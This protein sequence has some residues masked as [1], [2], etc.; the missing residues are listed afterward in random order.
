V[1]HLLT[2]TALPLGMSCSVCCSSTCCMHPCQSNWQG[3][4]QPCTNACAAA[5]VRGVK[6][7]P[8]YPQEY[9]VRLRG[10]FQQTATC[11]GRLAMNDPNLQVSRSTGEQVCRHR[12][13]RPQPKH[14]SSPRPCLV[15]KCSQNFMPMPWRQNPGPPAQHRLLL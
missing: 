12:C 13:E 11:T 5:I 1:G 14:A 8:S 15:G 2:C 4:S 10:C 7:R 6:A 9:V 3:Q